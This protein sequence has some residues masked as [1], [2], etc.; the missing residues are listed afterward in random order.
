MLT[1][2]GQNSNVL[3]VY[4]PLHGKKRFT[5]SLKRGRNVRI[6]PASSVFS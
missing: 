2:V 3:L 4:V 5:K 6:L 1:V